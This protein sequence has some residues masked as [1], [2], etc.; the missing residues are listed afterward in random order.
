MEVMAILS[1]LIVVAIVL[2]LFE[3]FAPQGWKKLGKAHS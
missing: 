2:S 3:I 1:A